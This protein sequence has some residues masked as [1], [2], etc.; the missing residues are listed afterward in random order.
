MVTIVRKRAAPIA[1]CALIHT[2]ETDPPPVP[3][4]TVPPAAMRALGLTSVSPVPSAALPA[5]ASPLRL[6]VSGVGIVLALAAGAWLWWFIG[7]SGK[8]F[9]S[10]KTREMA[11]LIFLAP[12]LGCALPFAVQLARRRRYALA[13]WLLALAP[14]ASVA[15]LVLCVL[16]ATLLSG[17]PAAQWGV[18]LFAALFWSEPWHRMW[19]RRQERRER[20]KRQVQTEVAAQERA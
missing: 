13:A 7:L 11:A 12:V 17:L 18:V 1:I 3:S 20:E 2:M 16:L 6:I 14:V 5:P 9:A 8:G 4:A 19:K 15:N 10:T